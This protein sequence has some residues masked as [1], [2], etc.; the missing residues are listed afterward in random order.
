MIRSHIEVIQNISLISSCNQKSSQQRRK[1]LS[2]LDG[3]S[4]TFTLGIRTSRRQLM[5]Y[6][7]IKT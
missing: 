2:R 6:L 7:H 3:T 1:I 4:T 5:R